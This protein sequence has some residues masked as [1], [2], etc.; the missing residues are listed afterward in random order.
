M[1]KILEGVVVSTKLEKTITVR[2]EERYRHP[3]YQ[4]VIKKHKRY[5]AHNES[6]KVADGDTVRIEETRPLS[7]NKHFKVIEVVKK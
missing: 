2:V 6:V 1:A 3:L 5:L 4:K 7:K